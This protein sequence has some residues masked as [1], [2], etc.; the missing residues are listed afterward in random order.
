MTASTP[1]SAWPLP[2]DAENA[3]RALALRAAL[4]FALSPQQQRRGMLP[5]EER[6][7]ELADKFAAWLCHDEDEDAIDLDAYL[8]QRLAEK[9]KVFAVFARPDAKAAAS[10]G[11][12]VVC[13]L[14]VAT[15]K[16]VCAVHPFT[17]EQED[18]IAEIVTSALQRTRRQPNSRKLS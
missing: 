14:D 7:L 17:R 15:G 1:N 11:E 5:T 3:G 16:P 10:Q 6:V 9:A 2:S 12:T 8:A 18:R 13:G 4:D